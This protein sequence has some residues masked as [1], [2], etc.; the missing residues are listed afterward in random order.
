MKV[1]DRVNYKDLGRY[2]GHAC[3]VN[4][5]IMSTQGQRW[6]KVGWSDKLITK[7]HIHDLEVINESR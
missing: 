7:E 1:G 4:G 2:S 5:V 3:S 6:V